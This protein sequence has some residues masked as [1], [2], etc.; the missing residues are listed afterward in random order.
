METILGVEGGGTK[1][2]WILIEK[3]ESETRT[4]RSG[5]LPASNFRLTPPERLRAMFAE[6]P[7]EAGRVGIFLAGCVTREDNEQLSAIGA[8]IWPGAFIVTGGDRDSGMAAALQDRDGI[9]VNAGTGSSITGQRDGKIEKAGGWGH[10]LGDAGGGYYLSLQALRLTL[11]EYDLRRGEARLAANILRALCL[12]NFDEL[13]RW[14]QAADKMEIATLSPVVFEAAENGDERVREILDGGARMLAEYTAAVARRL[15]L[16]APEVR[17]LGGLFQCCAIY[18]AAFQRELAKL[19]PHAR[20]EV[21]RN[22]PEW[23]A[24]WLAAHRKLPARQR[25]EEAGNAVDLRHAATEQANARSEKLDRMPAREF[26]ELFVNEERCVE[27]AL[28]ECIP[29]LAQGI[30]YL[31]AI[32]RDGGRLFYVGAGTSGRLGVLDA[33][34]IPPTFGAS[35]EAVQGIIAGGVHALHRSVEGAEDESGAGALAIEERGVSQRDVVCGITASGRTPFVLG[36]LDRAKHLGARTILLTCNPQRPRGPTFD[37]EINLPTGPELLAGSTRLKAGTATK[38]ALNILTTGAMVA[39]GKARGNRMIDL[40]A[41]NAKLRDRAA[42]LVAEIAQCDY[43]TASELLAARDWN[44]RAAIE[45]AQER[46]L[47]IT[48]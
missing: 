44:L 16:D 2:A 15:E 37:L 7:R 23:G 5:K 3:D 22:A 12:N 14:A 18:A 9:A 42:R 41:S 21:A 45:S 46:K 17:L 48:E 33:S 27:E 32:L 6:L 25:A 4:I 31:A 20:V 26:A 1:T 40:R 24:A 35:P 29:A 28:R 38:V 34:E 19:L 11:R 36:A 47:T 30:E 10:I 8:E 43:D 13:V 39:L